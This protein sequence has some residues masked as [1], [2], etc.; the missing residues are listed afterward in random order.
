MQRHLLFCSHNI[1]VAR[2]EYLVNL[3][4]TLCTISHGADGLHTTSF[5]DAVDTS[6][7]CCHK[8]GR[9]YVALAIRR[10]AQHNLF[11]A[12]YLGRSGEH[13]YC[14]EQWSCATRDV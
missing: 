4:H 11:A 7:A 5:E 6:Y 14:R 10:S 12:C 1:L 13:Q 9:I 8:D 3:W 2:T